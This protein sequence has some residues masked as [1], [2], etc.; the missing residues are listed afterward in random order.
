MPTLYNPDLKK[1]FLLYTFAFDNLLAIVLTQKDKMNDEC[2]ISF[3]SASMQG[4]ELN[5][6]TIN[7]QSYAVYR[8]MKNFRPY[9]VKTTTSSTSLTQQ[10]TRYSYNNS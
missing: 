6:P 7:K 5:Y 3:M 2:P 1:D 10:Y 8:L 9:L 4:L